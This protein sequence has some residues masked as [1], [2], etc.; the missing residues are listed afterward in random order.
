MAYKVYLF[1]LWMTLV[2]S[3][4][5]D[6]ILTLQQLLGYKGRAGD[7]S[8]LDS[9]FLTA[10]LTTNVA[11]EREFLAN[12]GKRFDVTLE[13]AHY[14]A[15]AALLQSERDGVKRY[16]EVDYV[17]GELNRRGAQTGIVSNLWPFPVDHIFNKLALGAHFE[18]LVFSFEVGSRKPDSGIF[19]DAC[20]RFGVHPSECLMIGDSLGSDIAGASAVG[21]PSVLVNRGGKTVELPAGAKAVS[22]LIELL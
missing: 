14:A 16:D 1:D 21:M 12:I 3:L 20:R 8:V 5:T 2:H 18:H 22:S 11:G 9:E 7:S 4:S 19:L 17:L 10:C 13:E 6:P 15:F